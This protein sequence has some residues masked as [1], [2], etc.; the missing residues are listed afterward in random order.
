MYICIKIK[1]N[2]GIIVII[3][4]TKGNMHNIDYIVGTEIFT[5]GKLSNRKYA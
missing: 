2:N 5:K 1:I 4:F 3:S